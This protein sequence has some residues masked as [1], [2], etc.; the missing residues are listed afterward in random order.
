LK[1]HA[2]TT[3]RRSTAYSRI[4]CLIPYEM[5]NLRAVF[6]TV[7]PLSLLMILPPPKHAIRENHEKFCVLPMTLSPKAIFRIPCFCEAFFSQS[8]T[9]VRHILCWFAWA[10]VKSFATLITHKNEGTL[11]NQ[12]ESYVCRLTRL[13]QY[14]A[15][16]GCLGA[17][18]LHNLPFS[19]L[20]VS[21]GNFAYAFEYGVAHHI[22]SWLL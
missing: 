10:T 9:H 22:N 16:V 1:I 14:I 7:L 2:H 17:E 18:R 21:V 5:P 15:L 11:R 20:A 3:S 12:A 19:A 8:E 6:E 13:S 4:P